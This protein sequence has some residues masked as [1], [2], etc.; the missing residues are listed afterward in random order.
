MFLGF[1]CGQRMSGQRDCR[2]GA[3][4]C[5][6]EGGA[7]L[8]SSSN[9]QGTRLLGLPQEAAG[10]IEVKCLCGKVHIFS[11]V[12]VGRMAACP[13]TK[14]RFRIPARNGRV[15]RAPS[16]PRPHP[17][18]CALSAQKERQAAI[19]IVARFSPTSFLLHV[20]RPTIR[21]DGKTYKASWGKT[22]YAHVSPGLHIVEVSF[23]HPLQRKAGRKQIY[24]TVSRGQ[25][26]RLQYQAPQLSFMQ[27]SLRETFL[28]R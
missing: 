6:T 3:R 9:H 25:I 27:G 21:V 22:E 19:E 15:I 26:R 12:F 14:R 7:T 4:R 17:A 20:F 24:L 16:T 28:R 2:R 23:S 18:G 13:T 8:S 1:H 10:L 11:N 5:G